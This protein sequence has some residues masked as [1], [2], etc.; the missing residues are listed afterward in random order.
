MVFEKLNNKVFVI[1]PTTTTP[2]YYYRIMD[3]NNFN[4][5]NY[6]QNIKNKIQ[7]ILERPTKN[8]LPFDILDSEIDQQT[9]LNSLKTKQKQMKYGEIWQMVIGEYNTFTDLGVGHYTGLDILSEER[10]IAMELK[11]RYN[12]DNA[13]SRKANLDKLVKY[14]KD[15]PDYECI[16]G[17]INEKN[18]EGYIKDIEHNNEKIKYYSGDKLFTL[19][20]GDDKIEIIEFVK[21]C[22]NIYSNK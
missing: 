6:L 5:E 19:I 8:D 4:L 2:K 9:S 21:K 10:K 16:Y 7:E 11:N 14:K 20:F 12:T 18:T 17:I 15:H 3:N 13:S 1:T 22:V